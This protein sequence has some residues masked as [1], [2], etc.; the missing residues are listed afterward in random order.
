[1]NRSIS[2]NKSGL[3]FGLLLFSFLPFPGLSQSPNSQMKKLATELDSLSSTHP[4]E[5]IY[6]QTSKGIYE[7]LEDLWFKAYLLDAQ[8][9]APSSLSRTLYLQMINE[10]TKRVVWQEKYE[11]QNGFV[12]GHVYLQDTLRV[13]D[14]LLS[15]YTGSSFFGDSSEMKAVRR[16]QVRKELKPN[17]DGWIEPAK[18][19]VPS[20]NKT[21]HFTTFPEGGNLVAGISNK[22]AFK[23]VN[24][25]GTPIDV[26]G[27]LFED[28]IPFLTVKSSHAG[29]GS[30]ELTPVAGKKY[31]IRLLEPA[32]DSTYFL[33][34]VC[35][36]GMSLQL[37]SRDK[38]FL[39]FKVSQSPAIEKKIIYLRGHIRGIVC[40]IARGELLNELKI[41]I[42]LKEF[43]FQGIAEFTLFD[44]NLTPLAERLLY[45]NPEKKL[46][47]TTELNKTRYE[48]KEKATLKISVKDQNG[49][50]IK[51]NLGVSIYDKLYQ[52]QADPVNI[53]T[54]YYLTSQLRGRI[55]DPAYYFDRK[56]ENREAALDL[57]MLTQGWRR[58]IWNQA[59]LEASNLK[60]QQVLFDGVDGEVHAKAK[61]KKAASMQQFVMV[62]FPNKN[63]ESD[64]VIADNA[65]RFTITPEYLKTGQGNYVY[66][67]PMT[68]EDFDPR[69]SLTDPFQTINRIR[70][71]KEI[72][73]PFPGPM[74]VLKE[75]ALID[76][77]IEGRRTIKLAE[78][79]V[80]ARG[81]NVFRDKY[82]GHLDSL[83]KLD[84]NDDWVCPHGFL[85]NYRKG[86]AHCVGSSPPYHQCC[87][88]SLKAKPVEGKMYKLVKYEDVGRNDGRWI[89]TD[90]S[91]V[92][93]HY[94]KFTEDE[95]LKMNNLSRVKAYYPD[96]QFYHVE[97][98]DV[99]NPD[100]AVDF[101]N[102]LFWDPSV[103]T[104]ANGEA[105]IDFF[106][107]DLNSHFV[108]VV[109][110]ANGDGLLG[111]ESIEFAVLKT[112]PIKQEK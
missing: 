56:N 25:D 36:E 38:D 57:L 103:I 81:T 1:M 89:L 95:L 43:P 42:P 37:I 33:P 68:A 105:I 98:D 23:A 14:Y 104:D 15:A 28:T 87:A 78:V 40:C 19:T 82:I 44:D 85:H 31:Y 107:S 84:L 50:P 32:T 9:F 111:N 30:V 88:D 66:I 77:Y 112:K 34:K 51:T 79:T 64:L 35:S 80:S 3:F 97:Y 55:Y 10:I 83:V 39:E 41:K 96:R 26:E 6:I 65:G 110:G 63:E 109:E 108:G 20:K 54:H 49:Q 47:I 29:M 13:G 18:L 94:P 73:Y 100:Q 75:E 22:L 45:V 71:V 5:L 17:Y 8:T 60:D 16:I 69:I 76:P 93:Y 2:K 52:N 48:T 72:C 62:F 59:T 102:T 27:T 24:S 12:N 21:I 7:P 90:L 99:S 106:C 74:P 61:V 53:L 46:F 11:V 67:K 70:K 91:A 86:Y 101:R 4:H 92:E 58:Y